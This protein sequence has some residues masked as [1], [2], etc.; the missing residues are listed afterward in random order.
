M[1]FH[2]DEQPSRN[3]P[4]FARLPAQSPISPCPWGLPDTPTWR[5]SCRSSSLGAACSKHTSAC[6]DAHCCRSKSICDFSK[7]IF[8]RPCLFN[9]FNFTRSLTPSVLSHLLTGQILAGRVSL[10]HHTPSPFSC[11]VTFRGTGTFGGCGVTNPPA[12]SDLRSGFTRW[13][14]E[15]S[16]FP[17]HSGTAQCPLWVT[18]LVFIGHGWSSD[19]VLP[20]TVGFGGLQLWLDSENTEVS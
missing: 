14:K 2:E 11:G 1:A 7:R 20:V 3:P 16:A 10:C 6:P 18:S 9:S 12:A 13:V 15:R 8:E 5:A 4:G 19:P 17:E